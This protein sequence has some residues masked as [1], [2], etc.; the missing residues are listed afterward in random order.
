MPDSEFDPHESARQRAID[1][2]RDKPDNG[3]VV[4]ETK[5]LQSI[6][7]LAFHAEKDSIRT[8]N[9]ELL[10]KYYPEFLKAADKVDEDD[11]CP[12]CGHA[13]KDKDTK[14]TIAFKEP[15]FDENLLLENSAAQKQLE[16]KNA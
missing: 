8:K 12:L 7:D 14:I 10:A 9:L 13:G 1:R 15:V 6:A 5:V 2:M 4:T 3:I 11:I 16:S